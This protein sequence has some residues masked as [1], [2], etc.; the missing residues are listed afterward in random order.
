MKEQIIS[1]E[2]AKLAKELGLQVGSRSSYILYHSS[3]LYNG[4]ENHPESHKK[5]EIRLDFDFYTVN[6]NDLFDTSSENYTIYEALTQ[7]LLQKW[8]RE[9]NN[10]HIE[11][12]LNNVIG[13]ENKGY[14]VNISFG[15][16]VKFIP[17]W[18]VHKDILLFKTYEEAL[19]K[20]LQE[21]LKLLQV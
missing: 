7:S 14:T 12:C 6:N 10:I 16:P 20:G 2:T 8:L 1:F 11:I 15:N 13:K 17:Y 18:K 21:S 4:D 19:E 9:K 5:E 3:F